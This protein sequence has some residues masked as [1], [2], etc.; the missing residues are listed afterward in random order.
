MTVGI[1]AGG[2]IGEAVPGILRDPFATLATYPGTDEI[3]LAQELRLDLR[4]EDA[5]DLFVEVDA[6]VDHRHTNAAASEA[7]LVQH[8][9]PDVYGH[10]V[11]QLPHLLTARRLYIRAA[12]PLSRQAAQG[13]QRA[14]AHPH[15]HIT[16][17]G[18][19][20]RLGY[21]VTQEPAA[22]KRAIW[23]QEN[24]A[25]ILAAEDHIAL[26]IEHRAGLDVPRTDKLPTRGA[27]HNIDCK[28]RALLNGC[29]DGRR[30][31]REQWRCLEMARWRLE[32]EAL[33]AIRVEPVQASILSRDVQRAIAAQRRLRHNLA[34]RNV[35]VFLHASRM[36]RVY[37]LVF[38]RQVNHAVRAD[39]GAEVVGPAVHRGEGPRDDTRWGDREQ[40]AG[41]AHDVELPLRSNSRCG[42]YVTAQ[43]EV[44]LP[45][46]QPGERVQ[47]IHPAVFVNRVHGPVQTHG[48]A[49]H[50]V[51]TGAGERPP[52]RAIGVERVHA[53]VLARHV[54]AAVQ[55]NHGRRL[56]RSAVKYTLDA[57]RAVGIYDEEAAVLRH[58]HEP[59]VG[60]I[61][62]RRPLYARK[63]MD[64]PKNAELTDP[65]APG[66]RFGGRHGLVP[67][68]RTHPR[69]PRKRGKPAGRN[70]RPDRVN[71]PQLAGDLPADARHRAGGGCRRTRG[72]DDRERLQLGGKQATLYIGTRY[73]RPRR[74]RQRRQPANERQDRQ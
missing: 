34:V 45:R 18:D 2:V 43:W 26:Q 4:T 13:G 55:T 1:T 49:C 69:L 62:D 3:G 36:N 28:E 27:A 14:A 25:L 73:Q 37:L 35:R 63:R 21:L 7:R 22:K 12:I 67:D 57:L 17:R 23:T 64:A 74:R 56:E 33:R 39:L 52:G 61:G 50:E 20:P 29:V 15:G 58:R 6:A 16:R 9:S 5:L 32:Q 38:P 60:Q 8:V 51:V 42:H 46:W 70:R 47:G 19:A 11:G 31:L 59:A 71:Q 65:A 48:H 41:S 72:D 68:D 30:I 40:L 24:Q 54:Y 66:R 10:W 53:L 44:L